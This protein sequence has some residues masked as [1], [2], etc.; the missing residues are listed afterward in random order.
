MFKVESG[1]HEHCD[2]YQERDEMQGHRED[3]VLFRIS[4]MQKTRGKTSCALL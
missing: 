4:G 2:L 1:L 3:R